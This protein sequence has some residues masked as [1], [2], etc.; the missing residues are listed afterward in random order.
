[1]GEFPEYVEFARKYEINAVV[2]PERFWRIY[3]NTGTTWD[4]FSA[5]WRTTARRKASIALTS[6]PGLISSGSLYAMEM[7]FL[8]SLGYCASRDGTRLD[9]GRR[10]TVVATETAPFKRPP[11]PIQEFLRRVLPFPRFSGRMRR[12]L[13]SSGPDQ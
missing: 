5:F 10:L 6:N 8:R 9:F 13:S 4:F 12:V 11:N 2:V 7:N 1:M 3:R